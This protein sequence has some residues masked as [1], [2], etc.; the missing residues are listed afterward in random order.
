MKRILSLITAFARIDRKTAPAGGLTNSYLAVILK[1]E[2][3][4]AG[5]RLAPQK[6]ITQKR[7][8]ACLEAGRLLLFCLK[9]QANDTDDH[10]TELKQI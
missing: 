6:L 2:R 1:I 7:V 5:R 8:T 9:K 4:A 3:G 10:K